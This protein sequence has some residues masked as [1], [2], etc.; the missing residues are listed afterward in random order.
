M[1]GRMRR[2][3]SLIGRAVGGSFF[4]EGWELRITARCLED[5]LNAGADANFE[6]VSGLKIV[7]ERTD[8]TEGGRQVTPLKCGRPVW[9]VAHQNDHRGATWYDAD[10]EVVWLLAYRRHRSGS[11]DDF[12]PYVKDELDEHNE[13]LPTAEDYKGL[14]LERDNRFVEAVRIEAPMILQ[15]ARQE[16]GT[17]HR[18]M[19]GGDLDTG[20]SIEVADDLEAITI[21][22][23]LGAID[24]DSVPIMLAA[25]HPSP[26][27]WEGASRL[28]SRELEP[29]EIAMTAVVE[30]KP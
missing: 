30:V 25:F 26:D 15:E 18:Y 12:F 8:H 1:A 27:D 11:G 2:P 19:L 9:V 7:R 22:F 23:R 10:E 28:P 14:I 5:D 13:L 17:E 24:W 6:D 3:P 16:P 21:A 4:A 29:G 20:I